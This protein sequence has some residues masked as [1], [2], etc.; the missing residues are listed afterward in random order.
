MF[1]QRVLS[2]HS[3][4]MTAAHARRHAQRLL[5]RDLGFAREWFGEVVE[6]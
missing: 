5:T 3:S 4:W 6:P 1:R 2:I